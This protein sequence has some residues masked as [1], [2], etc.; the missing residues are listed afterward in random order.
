MLAWATAL[1]A[2]V[3]MNKN[4]FSSQ[5]FHRSCMVRRRSRHRVQYARSLERPLSVMSS[6]GLKAEGGAHW[7]HRVTDR[8]TV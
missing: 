4:L 2:R 7:H 6:S 5:I 8:L 3:G 1:K